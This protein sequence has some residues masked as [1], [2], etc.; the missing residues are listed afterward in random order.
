MVPL[1][2][3][4]DEWQINPQKRITLKRELNNPQGLDFA[5]QAGPLMAQPRT[6]ELLP[7]NDMMREATKPKQITSGVKLESTRALRTKTNITDVSMQ[8]RRSFTFEYEGTFHNQDFMK[9]KSD[10][11]SN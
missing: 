5:S 11:Q 7:P 2:E 8:G 10:F 3:L 9:Q 4:S 6:I 1:E